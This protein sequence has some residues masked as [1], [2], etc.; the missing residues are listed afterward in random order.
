MAIYA[1]M[2]EHLAELPDDY[3]DGD[4]DD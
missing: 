1:S 2:P 3:T 4:D